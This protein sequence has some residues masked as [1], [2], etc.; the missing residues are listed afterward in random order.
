M[1]LK[2]ILDTLTGVDDALKSFYVEADG[3][4]VLQLDGIDAH[5]EIA[6][7]KN[8]YER[9]KTDKAASAAKVTDLEKQIAELAKNKPDEAAIAA[10]RKAYEDQ[11]AALNG[12]VSD[13]TGKLTGVTRDR[14]LDD[15]LAAAGVMNPTFRKAAIKMLAD[16]VKVDGD[17]IVVE[18]G[19]GPVPLA[20]H[21]KKWAAGE[22]KDFVTPAQGGGGTGND[23]GTGGGKTV[24]ARELDAK[25]P[26]EK[27]AFFAANPGLTVTD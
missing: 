7:L 18:T 2:T 11:I 24:S 5:P 6:T 27:A 1:A 17:K 19:M 26:Q 23:R 10:A 3:K 12:T 25:T 14:S 20:D 15:A 22:G 9:V 8:A 16:Q 4:F 21:V 13:L